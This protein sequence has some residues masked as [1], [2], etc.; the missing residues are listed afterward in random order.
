MKIQP[1]TASIQ[2]DALEARKVETT[3]KTRI[4]CSVSQPHSHR[5]V[6]SK[7][8]FHSDNR[9]VYAFDGTPHVCSSC[10][11]QSI[12]LSYSYLACTKK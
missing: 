9:L 8:H 11:L 6:S 7:L 3:T 4:L 12:I 10:S 1:N 2:C 5:N